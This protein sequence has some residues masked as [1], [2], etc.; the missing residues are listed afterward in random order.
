MSTYTYPHTI[1]NGAGER[2]T[3]LRRVQD[4]AGDLLEVENLVKPGSGPPMHVHHQQEEA[5]TWCGGG[6]ATSGSED[7]R[8]SP[9]P[10]R[11]SS[12]SRAS[13]T[14]SGTLGKRTS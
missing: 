1:E 2:L 12:S 11:R 4:A 8:G 6:S 9:D 7:S 10:V 14:G 13:R 5:L 3:F